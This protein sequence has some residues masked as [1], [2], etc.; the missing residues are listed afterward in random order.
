[1]WYELMS[2]SGMAFLIMSVI[3]YVVLVALVNYEEFGKATTIIAAY[4]LFTVFFTD[5]DLIKLIT[6]N[7]QIVLLGAV[8]YVIAGSIWSIVKWFLFVYNARELPETT[9]YYR[10]CRRVG[11]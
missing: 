1:M 3:A 7:L 6:S 4:V 10:H 8:G 5:A 11:A 2:V 9:W